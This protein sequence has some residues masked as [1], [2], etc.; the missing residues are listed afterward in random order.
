DHNGSGSVS[1]TVYKNTSSFRMGLAFIADQKI[2]IYQNTPDCPEE[3][4]CAIAP[5]LCAPSNFNPLGASRRFRDE[6]LAKSSR[7]QRYTKLYYDFSGEIVQQMFFHPSLV[8]RSLEIKERY[9]PVIEAMVKGE[10]AT[11]TEGDLDEIDG[12]LNAI[13]ARGSP[14]LQATMKGLC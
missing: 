14:E 6:V 13:A 3:F 12:F 1:L 10:G 7:G 2:T 5:G 8:L 4:F 9:L 11:L